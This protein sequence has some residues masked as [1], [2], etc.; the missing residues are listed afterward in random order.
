MP[1]QKTV[2]ALKLGL[3]LIFNFS[4]KNQKNK[5][6]KPSKNEKTWTKW[7]FSTTYAE[8]YVGFVFDRLNTKNKVQ[9]TKYKLQ[10][11]KYNYGD[12]A[13]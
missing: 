2:F 13:R 8:N 12:D 10:S 3:I 9:N 4:N 7:K 11:T 1:L 5:V 6:W